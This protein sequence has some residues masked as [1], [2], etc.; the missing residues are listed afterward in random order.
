MRKRWVGCSA[1]VVTGLLLGGPGSAAVA[2]ELTERGVQ[3]LTAILL[4][5]ASRTPTQRKLDTSLL[6][7]R[8][9]SLGQAM[10][11]G[12]PP[13]RRVADRAGVGGDGMVVVD[14]RADVTDD[15]LNAIAAA[16]GTTEASHTIEVSSAEHVTE[17]KVPPTSHSG[18]GQPAGRRHTARSP[19]STSR[20][21]GTGITR[22]RTLAAASDDEAHLDHANY[23]LARDAVAGVAHRA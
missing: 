13:L 22:L 19:G 7:A 21:S 3:Q 1:F 18:S 10:V 12:L 8:R 11:Q 15:L 16:G 4:E 5:K 6:Y 2:Q 9:E 17:V 23:E 20:L 14:I